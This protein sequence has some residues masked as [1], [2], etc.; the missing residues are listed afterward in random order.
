KQL[1]AD[2]R[3]SLN[4]MVGKLQESGLDTKVILDTLQS[5]VKETMDAVHTDYAKLAPSTPGSPAPLDLFKNDMNVITNGLSMLESSTAS[6][7][8]SIHGMWLRFA[9][10][11]S[12]IAQGIY[13]AYQWI[14]PWARHSPSLVD[15]VSTAADAINKIWEKRAD[16]MAKQFMRKH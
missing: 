3:D 4:A 15:Q 6:S 9:Q 11:I 7:L 13:Q 8:I 12:N 16:D 1:T 14:N 10:A 2:Q 5:K